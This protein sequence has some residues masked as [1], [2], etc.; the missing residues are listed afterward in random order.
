[1]KSITVCAN[2]RVRYS[3]AIRQKS[4]SR[5]KTVRHRN[6]KTRQTSQSR[7]RQRTIKK[8]VGCADAKVQHSITKGR[9]RSVKSIYHVLPDTAMRNGFS[10]ATVILFFHVNRMHLHYCTKSGE[11]LARR[12]E[13]MRSRLCPRCRQ[14]VERVIMNAAPWKA[15]SLEVK[16]ETCQVCKKKPP[17][18]SALHEDRSVARFIT[19]SSRVLLKQKTSM[20]LQRLRSRRTQEDALG[21]EKDPMPCVSR[22][23]HKNRHERYHRRRS[24]SPFA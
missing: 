17:V 13:Y 12:L 4:L 1:M 24:C 22:D 16:I 15:I 18:C 9:A 6:I 11:E 3:L 19:L 20:L 23:C 21:E 10:S 7:K 2:A 8:H 14:P 5:R